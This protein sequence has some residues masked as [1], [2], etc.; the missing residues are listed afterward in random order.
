MKYIES[1]L[2]VYDRLGGTEN[3]LDSNSNDNIYLTKLAGAPN[4]YYT[5]TE[6]ITSVKN[7]RFENIASQVLLEDGVYTIHLKSTTELS[8]NSGLL[9]LDIG[10][11]HIILNIVNL[12]YL[13]I[14]FI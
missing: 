9:I 7:Y 12:F 6:P 14:S 1:R 8:G 5:I 2:W 3:L 13:L 11:E 4:G 10:D